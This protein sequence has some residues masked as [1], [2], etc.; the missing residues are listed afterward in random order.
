M[1]RYIII[2]GLQYSG[3]TLDDMERREAAMDKYN[4]ELDEMLRLNSLPMPAM[5]EWAKERGLF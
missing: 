3:E 2:K 1:L 5:R 4:R